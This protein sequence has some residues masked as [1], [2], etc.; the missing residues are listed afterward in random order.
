M[1]IAHCTAN[2]DVKFG[3]FAKANTDCSMAISDFPL[4]QVALKDAIAPDP[5]V[6]SPE[7]WVTDAIAQMSGLRTANGGSAPLPQPP[8]TQALIPTVINHS[9]PGNL[10]PT[11]SLALSRRQLESTYLDARASCVVVM[12]QDAVVGILTERDVVQWSARQGSLDGVQIQEVMARS[13]ITITEAALDT[14]DVFQV[15][16]LLQH[17]QIRHLPVLGDRG[18]LLG[19]ITHETLRHVVHPV[20]LLRWRTVEEMMVREVVCAPP[21]A[22]ILQITRLM[23]DHRVSCVVITESTAANP[24]DSDSLST[25]KTTNQTTDKTIHVAMGHPHPF[26]PVPVVR[27]VG[28]ITER[29]LVQFHSGGLDLATCQAHAVMSAPLFCV[30]PQDRLLV[31]YEMMEQQPIRRVVVTGQQGEL[32][33]I[34]T[35]TNLLQLLNPLELYR[36]TE[37]LE[38]RV[39]QLEQERLSLLE[40]LTIQLEQQVSQQTAALQ[41]KAEQARLIYQ[42]SN[43]VRSSLDLAEILHTTVQELRSLLDCDRVLIYQF[44]PNTMG[45]VVSEV[46]RPHLTNHSILE[47]PDYNRQ[48]H[49]D[50]LTQDANGNLPRIRTVSDRETDPLTMVEQ[51]RLAQLQIRA[52]LTVPIVVSGTLWGVLLASQRD[53]PRHWQETEIELLEQLSIQVA[54][55]IQQATAYQQA[56]AELAERQHAELRLRER[57]S[58]NQAILMAIPDLMFRVGT[59]GRY[60]GFVTPR[61]AVDLIPRSID[62]VGQLLVDILEPEIAQR[63]LAYLDLAL[64]TGELQIY[65]QQVV[66]GDHIQHEEVRVVKSGADEALF[67]VRDITDRKRSEL[68]RNQALEALK[69]SELTNRVII[70]SIPDLLI[71]MDLQGNYNCILAGKTVQVKRPEQLGLGQEALQVLPASLFQR[72]MDAA[73]RAITTQELQIYEQVF[74][75]NGDLRNEEVRIAPLNDHEVLV[76]IRDITDRKRVEQSLQENE[77]KYRLLV[78]NQTDLVVRV[79]LEGRLTFVSPSYCEMFGK[80]EAELLNHPYLPLVHEADR[81][82]TNQA[83][84]ALRKPPYTCYVEQRVMTKEGWRWLGWSSKAI[85]DPHGNVIATVGV[86][87]D[88]TQLKQT[89]QALKQLNQDLEARVEERTQALRQLTSLQRAILNG[90]DYSIISTDQ[91]GIIQTFNAA[92]E[93]ML[94]YAAVEVIGR[95]TPAIIHDS[96]EIRDRAIALSQEL[97]ESIPPGFEVLV[98]KARRGLSSPNTEDEWTYIRKDGSRLPVSL[99]VTIMADPHGTIIGFV[100]IAKDITLRKQAA[101]QLQQTNEELRRATRLKDEFL[102]NMSHEL[103]TPLNAILGMAEGLQDQVFGGLNDMQLRAIKTI[104]T[105]GTHLLELINDILHLAKIEAGQVELHPTS[106]KITKLCQ[107]SLDFVRSQ[108][109]TKHINLELSLSSHLPVLYVDERRIRQVLINLL[110][111]AV[112]FTPNG[113]HVTLRAFPSPNPLPQT[114]TLAASAAASAVR[115][116]VSDTGIGIA[117]DNMDKLFKPFMQVDSALNRQY[118]GT[119]LGLSLVKR[120]VDLHGGRVGVTSEVGVGSCFTVDLPCDPFPVGLGEVNGHSLTPSDDLVLK[121]APRVASRILLAEDNLANINTISSYLK[122]KGYEI[123]VA[124]HGHDAIALARS[125]VPDLILMD[126]QM[127]GLDGITAIQQIRLDPQ[128]SSTPII[129]LTALAMDGDRERCLAAGA[130]DY[131]VKPV[132]L[133][134][135]VAIIEQFLSETACAP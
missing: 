20:D 48:L 16:T 88:I 35:Q 129:A 2:G 49:T 125:Q 111:N 69:Q 24:P 54:I 94:G 75:F 131:L 87:R 73:T 61:N 79:D 12:E 34:I 120:I 26:A 55:A 130:N 124:N 84:T 123:V 95:V 126:I 97:G 68:E 77:A 50:W 53:Q 72:R 106:V 113:G 59:D 42:I 44:Q 32:L 132:K 41:T 13:I 109:Q 81:E 14:T 108:A 116:S 10:L 18:Q 4:K 91:N 67:M 36:L 101:A 110:N 66:I 119:G 70:E 45:N 19:L 128:T 43:Q 100:G 127:P 23:A 107:S 74:D 83:R 78:E 63:H 3:K 98:A 9:A 39:F 21:S 114:D 38:Q 105:S 104:E 30:H 82:L 25:D 56:K 15:V 115:F 8:T 60:R 135:L 52:K 76:M 31:V 57:E 103:R 89:Q 118:E 96:Q 93:K 27:P 51:D 11:Y 122:A 40:N 121:Q 92:A 33:G 133:K 58:H 5:I 71:Q 7:T 6:V 47:T 112:K 117:P 17:H 62:P 46:I 85:L 65:E 37:F 86:G 28:I 29:D 80:T 99:S 134:Q 1:G 22:S 64:R 90:A 102:A